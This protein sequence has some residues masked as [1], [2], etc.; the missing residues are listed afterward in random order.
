MNYGT[1]PIL[2]EPIGTRRQDNIAILDFRAEKRF[3]LPRSARLGLILDVFNVT[4]SNVA[5]NI[6]W[7]T[8]LLTVGAAQ[9]PTFGTPISV[10]PPRIARLGVKLDW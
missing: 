4:N 10:L 3:S 6:R 2:V 5:T 9:I 1:Q 7:T 8:G